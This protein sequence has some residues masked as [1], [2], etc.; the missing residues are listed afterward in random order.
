MWIVKWG[1]DE[2]EDEVTRALASED[3]RIDPRELRG[4]EFGD[5]ATT[6]IKPENRPGER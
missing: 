4:G 1:A 2:N 6:I 5:T 3:K